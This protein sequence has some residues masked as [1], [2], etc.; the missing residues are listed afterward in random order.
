MSMTCSWSFT[1][2]KVIDTATFSSGRQQLQVAFLVLMIA[3]TTDRPGALVYVAHNEKEKLIE[4]VPAPFWKG[5]NDFSDS[6]AKHQFMAAARGLP[7]P[8]AV[9]LCLYSL[10]QL[11]SSFART[12]FFQTPVG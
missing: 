2:T 1:I 3:Y 11:D 12:R 8:P 7:I 10:A 9:F 6:W 5:L 4:R